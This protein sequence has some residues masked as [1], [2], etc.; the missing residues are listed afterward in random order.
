MRLF[1]LLS[2]LPIPASASAAKD[3]EITAITSDSRQVTPGALFVAYKGVGVD[4]HD[5]LADAVARHAAAV[6]VER[7][8]GDLPVPVVQ[9]PNGREALAWLGAA[10]YGYPSREMR[11]VGVTGTD[12][13]TT[14][15][16][17]VY[18]ILRAAGRRAGLISTVNAVVPSREAGALADTV[19]DTGLHTTTPDA[20]EIQHYLAMMRDAG[21][22]DAVLETTS[23]GLVQHRVTGCEFD[24][25]VITNITH[26]HLDFHGSVQAYREA[27]SMLFRALMKGVPKPGIPK[28]SVLNRD[29]D[30][31]GLL[32][33]IPAERT[34]TYGIGAAGRLSSRRRRPS[35]DPQIR[36]PMDAGLPEQERQIAL[37]AWDIRQSPTGSEFNVELAMGAPPGREL[38][39][40]SLWTPL[41][42]TFN[43]YNVLA[44]TA[45]ALALGV[46]VPAIQA[47]VRALAAIPGRMERIDREQAFT[48]IVDFAHT[49]NGLARALEAARGLAISSP[50]TGSQILGRVIAVFGCAGLR[51][52]EKRRL[53]GEVAARLA[54]ITV[55]TAEDPR[56]EDLDAIMA[57]TAGAMA[58]SGRMEGRDFL[59]V[60]DRQLAIRCAVRKARPGDVV[61]VCGKGHEQS[62]CFGSVEYPWR[63]QDALAWAL[64]A[65]QGTEAPPP[66]VLPTGAGSP[67]APQWVEE[68]NP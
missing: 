51:D 23:H 55:I 59:R 24:V 20:M 36:R 45:A 50:D 11:V 4:G 28:T 12:G 58:G 48:A 9:V 27:K 3:V 47:G 68:P 42:G 61:I 62:M 44:A 16:N 37:T 2:G 32:A 52:R 22:G 49:P 17:L 15:A 64:D 63:D 19:Y 1:A 6:V 53:M 13:K 8:S 26:E 21:T 43:I 33:S 56:T 65:E 46:D 41:C 31:F 7:G 35:A 67:S 18:S 60:A 29:D 57:E 66:F 39:R 25:A 54:D 14:T 5:Y 10:W 30:S 40:W 34:V 38:A